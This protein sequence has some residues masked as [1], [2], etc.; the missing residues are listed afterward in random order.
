MNISSMRIVC[1]L[2]S[3]FGLL[4]N[5][6]T[7][8]CSCHNDI[9][10]MNMARYN[11]CLTVFSG[12]VDSLGQCTN[13]G[14]AIIFLIDK[15]YKGTYSGKITIPRVDC[16]SSCAFN[17]EKGQVYLVYLYPDSENQYKIIPCT[18]T[19]KLL[20]KKEIEGTL[21]QAKRFNTH[22]FLEKEIEIWEHEMA[23]LEYVA[24][25]PNSRI[26]T[27]YLNKKPTGDGKLKN[28]LPEGHWKYYYPEGHIKGTGN[29]QNGQKTGLWTEYTTY[30]ETFEDTSSVDR[31]R[32]LIKSSGVYID[33][34]KEGKWERNN[35]DGSTQTMYYRKGK[36]IGEQP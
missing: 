8:A 31:K 29:Y 22:S 6:L 19:R 5:Q 36:F 17:F 20:S 15:C 27:E 33:G 32:Y 3:F 34:L 16:S 23:L 35:L 28:G 26:K 2:L 1:F 25:N 14:R 18:G 21:T 9:E 7:L 10:E 30:Y 13:Q 24:A 11:D 4:F 12:K